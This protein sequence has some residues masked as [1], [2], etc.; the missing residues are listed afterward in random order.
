MRSDAN[1]IALRALRSMLDAAKPFEVEVAG[2]KVNCAV[3]RRAPESWPD[4]EL[5]GLDRAVDGPTWPGAVDVECNWPAGRTT[6]RVLVSHWRSTGRYRHQVGVRVRFADRRR[7]LLWITVPVAVGDAADGTSAKVRA[8]VSTFQRK[9][10]SLSDAGERLNDALQDALAESGLPLASARIPEVGE[11]EV[12]SGAVLPSPEIAFRRLVHLALLKLDFVDR[13]AEAQARGAPLYDLGRWNIK[14]GQLP[15][16]DDDDDEAE[17]AEILASR[18]RRHW[19][20]GFGEPK[21]RDE[22]LKGNFWQIGWDR[23]AKQPAAKRTWRRFAEIQKGD[24]FAIKGYGGTHDLSV[25][26]VGEVESVDAERGRVDL[27]RRSDIPLFRGK[28]PRGPDSGA[29]RDTLVPITRADVDGSGKSGRYD[30]GKSG[31][32]RKESDA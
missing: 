9:A 24:L 28:A 3:A 29:W 14:L 7:T 17:D 8:S 12:P 15:D 19:A 11:I 32:S 5:A 21:R 4:R 20:G 6:L 25:H 1:K 13:G 23:D 27:K 18:P 22:F 16:D 31:R 2:K 30:S 26:Y 10:D